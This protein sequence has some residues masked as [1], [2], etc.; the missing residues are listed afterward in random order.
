MNYDPL[1]SWPHCSLLLPSWTEKLAYLSSYTMTSSFFDTLFRPPFRPRWAI[2]APIKPS[3]PRATWQGPQKW[4]CLFLWLI[5]TVSLL[6]SGR[7]EQSTAP[8]SPDVHGHL[9]S[10]HMTGSSGVDTPLV[11][12]GDTQAAKSENNGKGVPPA[13]QIKVRKVNIPGF[14]S[15]SQERWPAPV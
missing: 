11:P 5:R 8:S 7:S 4:T 12:S 13:V 6:L 15:V 10:G 9:F 3:H 2:H 1:L 14:Y